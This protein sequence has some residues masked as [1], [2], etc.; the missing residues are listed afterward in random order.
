MART[1]SKLDSLD[2][3]IL[4]RY[5]RDSRIP[6]SALGSAVGLSAAAVQRRLKRMRESGVI[7]EVAQVAPE[8]LGYGVTCIVGVEL[9][10]E[11]RADLERFR[12]RMA[13]L[14]CVQ[15]CYY[16]TGNIDF[17]LVVLARDTAEYEA[18]TDSALLDD[19]NVKSFVTHM[20]LAR[21]KVGLDVPIPA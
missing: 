21:A 16:V 3:K 18:F 13:Q 12:K 8:A 14:A 1:D 19:A 7:A 2:L 20:V 15:Q 5:Q 9:E 10:S 6:A 11:R 4:K 17:L